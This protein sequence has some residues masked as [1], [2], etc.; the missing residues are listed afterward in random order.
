MITFPRLHQNF[1]FQVKKLVAATNRLI[2]AAKSQVGVRG[3]LTRALADS[4]FNKV[5]SNLLSQKYPANPKPLNAAYADWKLKNYGFLDSWF[6]DGDLFRNIRV[7]EIQDGR[8]VGIPR[9]IKAGGKSWYKSKGD[10]SKN[11]NARE[12]TY[13]GY[14]NE[15]GSPSGKIPARPVFG[16]TLAD[17]VKDEARGITI[18]A[19]DRVF[20]KWEI[21]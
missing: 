2:P 15:W 3:E 5:R 18:K 17:F 13:Y 11:Y 1:S 8:G 14:L 10:Q 4:Y 20:S 6:L 9:G 21:R 19:A 16:P 7:M 12:I